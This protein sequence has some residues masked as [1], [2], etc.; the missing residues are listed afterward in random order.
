MVVKKLPSAYYVTGDMDRAVAFYRDALGL[1]L[2]SRELEKGR[3]PRREGGEPRAS[4]KE[5]VTAL[6]ATPS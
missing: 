4:E 5:D 3:R 2:E 6:A 1:G